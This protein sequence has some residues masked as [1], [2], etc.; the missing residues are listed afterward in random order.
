MRK[1]PMHLASAAL[2]LTGAGLLGAA[3]GQGMIHAAA[4]TRIA[5]QP[6]RAG[7]TVLAVGSVMATAADGATRVLH[8][9]DPIYSGDTLVTGDD[10]YADLDFEDGGRMLLRPGTDFQIQTYHFNPAA[11]G[12]ALAPPAEPVTYT[13]AAPSARSASPVPPPTALQ[14]APALPPA[15]AAPPQAEQENAFFRLIKGGFRAISGFIGHVDHQDYAVETPVATI[16]IRG[17]GYE[18]R[19]CTSHCP[20]GEKGLYTGVGTGA[21]AIRNQAGERIATAGHFGYIASR[22]A[23]FRRLRHAPRALQHMRLPAR[24]RARDTRNFHRVQQ[25]RRQRWQHI[26]REHSRGLRHPYPHRPRAQPR[27]RPPHPFARGLRR[28]ENPLRASRQVRR[29]QRHPRAP[30]KRKK[31]PVHR[32]HYRRH[33]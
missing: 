21:I 29:I 18:V 23:R 22:T 12:F 27:R 4:P 7:S 9:G 8:D 1:C 28:P 15:S 20:Q 11:H 14:P 26:A 10:G 30:L 2:A 25:R 3:W 16:G 13:Q 17:T 31:K 33:R 6:E 5:A 19:Y 24:Y 32:R